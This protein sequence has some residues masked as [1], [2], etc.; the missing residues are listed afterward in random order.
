MAEHDDDR[1]KAAKLRAKV[2]KGE[3]LTARQR[4][5][6]EAYETRTTIAKAKGARVPVPLY[7]AAPMVGPFSNRLEAMVAREEKQ[8]PDASGPVD[9]SPAPDLTEP[10]TV[11]AHETV[12]VSGNVAPTE[13]TWVP[14]V[15]PA[16][17]GAEPTPPGAP[18]PPSAGTPLVAESSVAPQGDP[19]AAEQFAG[20]VVFITT[21]GLTSA[22]ELSRGVELPAQLRFLV[23]SAELHGKYLEHVGAC[24]KRVAIKHNFRSIP[25]ADEV[26]V[27]GSVAGSVAAFV[28]LQKRRLK[29]PSKPAPQPSSSSSEPSKPDAPEGMPSHI[30]EALA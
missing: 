2:K 22:L 28:A 24:A 23:E 11:A 27:A 21:M 17:E 12:P 9:I 1:S 5:W 26:V 15:P 30:A 4:T 8:L 3:G 20:L 25:M 6:L 14:E 19:V 18:E 10:Q 13:A 16:G 29:A 7:L